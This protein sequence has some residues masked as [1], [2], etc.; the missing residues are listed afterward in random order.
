MNI[1]KLFFLT[2]KILEYTS[3]GISSIILGNFITSQYLSNSKIYKYKN[4]ILF[5]FTLN[6]LRVMNNIQKNKN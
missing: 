5:L 6:N 2:K 1:T 3:L 4:Y